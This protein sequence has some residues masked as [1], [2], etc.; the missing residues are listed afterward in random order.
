MTTTIME[1]NQDYKAQYI[2]V[3]PDSVM[4]VL[5]QFVT[6]EEGIARFAY[7]VT[8]EVEEGRVDPLKV[9]LYMKT[10]EKIGEIV[11]KKLSEYYL[12]EAEKYGAKQFAFNGAE[13]SVGPVSTTYDYTVCNHP[14]WN[15]LTKLINEATTQ[16]KDIEALLK[17]LKS[18]QVLVIEGEAV[19]VQP[20][21]KNQKDGIKISIK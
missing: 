17:T 16:R 14:G 10:L 3:S 2:A 18:P 20:P 7:L 8:T 12:R 4:G 19:E 11:G 1:P 21:V 15:D 6:S 9:A 5:D 13:I